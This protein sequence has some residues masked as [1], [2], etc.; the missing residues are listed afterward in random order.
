MTQ[1]YC[2]HVIQPGPRPP[3]NI[4][5][6]YLWGAGCEFDSDGNSE[7]PD[8]ASWTKLTLALRATGERIDID[9]VSARPLILKVCG[10]SMPL[11]LKAAYFIIEQSGGEMTLAGC[12][13]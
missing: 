11:V 1:C 9:P 4:V 10:E 8:D 6:E 7:T 13:G 2:I 3:R 12:S 5:A